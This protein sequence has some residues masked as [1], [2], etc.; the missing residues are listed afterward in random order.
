M[1]CNVFVGLVSQIFLPMLLSSLYKTGTEASPDK[2]IVTE[3]V[4][5]IL[6]SSQPQQSKRYSTQ[7]Y[8]YC[9]QIWLGCFTTIC[10]FC[11]KHTFGCLSASSPSMVS[12]IL[13]KEYRTSSEALHS[14]RL[15]FSKHYTW[16]ALPICFRQRNVIALY[17]GK[18]FHVKQF[19]VTKTLTLKT[20]LR[21]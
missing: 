20:F 21:V 5:L 10:L 13:F 6:F 19:L 9:W 3:I 1:K 4:G 18:F 17:S 2:A 15:S 8:F 14:S 12:S 16:S 7:Q 11:T